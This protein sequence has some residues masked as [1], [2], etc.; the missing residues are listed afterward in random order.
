[1]PFLFFS[2]SFYSTIANRIFQ[3]EVCGVGGSS[4]FSVFSFS[5]GSHC[6]LL[7][8]RRRLA[9]FQKMTGLIGEGGEGGGLLNELTSFN[10]KLGRVPALRRLGL[11]GLKACAWG[12]YR[13]GRGRSIRS[14]R[15]D[16]SCGAVR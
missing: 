12:G 7:A 2:I 13:Y 1:M 10:A 6:S 3:V 11:L 8:L 5:S 14:R 4:F 15:S 16:E 9:N